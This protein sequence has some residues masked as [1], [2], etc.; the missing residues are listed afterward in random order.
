MGR[1]VTRTRSLARLF[2]VGTRHFDGR[3]HLEPL[4]WKPKLDGELFPTQHVFFSSFFKKKGLCWGKA[5]LK[6]QAMMMAVP[7]F[8]GPA[9]DC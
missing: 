5:N 7:S 2:P 8:Q 9:S 1:L 6:E 4:F 3:Y